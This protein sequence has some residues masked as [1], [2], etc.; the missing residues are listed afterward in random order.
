M[1]ADDI[2]VSTWFERTRTPAWGLFGGE[3]G[4]TTNVTLTV[5]GETVPLLKAN[6]VPAP[7]GARLHVATGGG[8]GYGEPAGRSPDL[9]EN[10]LI[11]GYTTS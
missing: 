11:D 7:V 10:D 6:Q 9:A 2:T 4:A 5:D 1:L 8:G 3:D